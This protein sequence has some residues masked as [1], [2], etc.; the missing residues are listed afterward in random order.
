MKH[1]QRE[2]LDN[3]SILKYCFVL[4]VPF[5]RISVSEG[6]LGFLPRSLLPYLFFFLAVTVPRLPAHPST[7]SLFSSAAANR[8]YRREGLAGAT[9]DIMRNTFLAGYVEPA[10]ALY[11][12][13]NSD[14]C[15]VGS[16]E[17]TTVPSL[18]RTNIRRGA[19]R[20][21][22]NPC[23]RTLTASFGHWPATDG[24]HI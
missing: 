2:A 19:R 9:R 14:G 18:W 17:F 24:W 7:V 5:R 13:Y 20:F 8:A 16:V 10:G 11:E 4:F 1:G 3:F 21:A 22:F 12:M 15:T 6:S 23:S